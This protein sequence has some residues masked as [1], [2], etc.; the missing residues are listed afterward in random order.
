M[1]TAVEKAADH[2]R[3]RILSGKLAAGERLPP[4][5]ELATELGINR[6]TL[7]AALAQLAAANLVSVRQG[8]GYLVR[9]WRRDGGP[10]LL[11][12]LVELE[13]P[14]GD[15]EV[16]ARDLLLVRRHL[17][18]AVLTRLAT[19]V[20][21]AARRRI[22][23]AVHRYVAAAEAGVDPDQAAEHDLAI[24]EA[25]LEATESPV[26]SLCFNPVASVLRDLPALRRAMY[27]D[28]LGGARSYALLLGWLEH[29]TAD[30]LPLV[31]RLLE[32]R[33][34]ITLARLEATKSAAAKSGSKP[35][36]R[37]RS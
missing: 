10:E 28:A 36:A 32:E 31:T 11:K 27:A 34:A 15:L 16:I 22:E 24:L 19:G 8:S 9:P 7:R 30:G 13:M 20:S 5:R 4:E 37:R 29:P 3:A 21:L 26:L 14:A 12:S 17:A 25:I 18:G 1:T 23:A 2:L 33:D 6:I 35:T